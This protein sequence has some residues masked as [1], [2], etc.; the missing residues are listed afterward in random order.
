MKEARKL[1]RPSK[2]V[3]YGGSESL[4][5]EK[6][7][8][9]DVCVDPGAAHTSLP[10]HTDSQQQPCVSIPTSSHYHHHHQQQQPNPGGGA[11]ITTEVA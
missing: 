6:T 5:K 2:G 4:G 3:A 11:A 8:R 9:R 1:S 7:E 10:P